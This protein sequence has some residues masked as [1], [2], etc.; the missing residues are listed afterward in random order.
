MASKKDS[1]DITTEVSDDE[2][3]DLDLDDSVSEEDD[4]EVDEEVEETAEN[5]DNDSIDENYENDED[6]EKKKSTIDESL[7][8]SEVDKNTF[9]DTFLDDDDDDDE[10][11]DDYENSIN[12]NPENELNQNL[13]IPDNERISRNILTKYEVVRL[14][15]TRAK[16]ISD[17]S[18]VFV[19]FD[20]KKSALELAELELKHKM[21]PLKVK[22]QLP[23][24]R[25][26]IWKLSELDI[27]DN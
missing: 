19:K 13:Q 21:M 2:F 14:I 20:G 10:D 4:E 15:G 7:T 24:G 17:G 18:K 11:E 5:E 26:E 8:K 16:Q 27:L 12:E 22:R 3:E 23:N 25:Y 1:I 6:L 9:T